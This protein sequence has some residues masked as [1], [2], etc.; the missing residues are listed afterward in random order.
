MSIFERHNIKISGAGDTALIFAHG[1]GC[2]QNM[3]RLVAPEFERDYRVVLFDHAGSGGADP[4]AYDRRNYASLQRY[5]EDI[6]SI[7]QA[8]APLGVRNAILAGH[9]VSAMIG[10]LAAIQAPTS[11]SKLI[12]VGPSPCYTNDGDYI[13]G[14]ERADIDSLLEFLDDN[15]LGWSRAMAP[16]IMGNTDRPALSTELSDSF[17]RTDPEAAK[18]FA[19]VT[20][21]SDNRKDLDLLT[22][23]SLILQCSDDAIAPETVGNYLHRHLAGSTLVK[24]QAVG[25]CPHLSSPLETIAAIRGYLHQAS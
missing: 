19:R 12:L 25:H 1:F 11:F 15:Y 4:K 5:A 16:V 20:F 3:W 7:R 21:L 24:L 8:L 14:F 10:I 18:Q 9:S 2:D 23:P 6:L 22:T 17:C 13:G